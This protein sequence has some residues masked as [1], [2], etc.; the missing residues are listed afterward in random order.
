MVVMILKYNIYKSIRMASYSGCCK[1][2]DIEEVEA[3][4]SKNSFS[5]LRSL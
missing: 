2:K 4:E 3:R 5:C 1:I